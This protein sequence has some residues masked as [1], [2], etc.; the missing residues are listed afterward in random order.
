MATGSHPG[1]P[2]GRM[3]IVA[4][5]VQ[6][7]GTGKTTLAASLA[8]AAAE[9]GEQVCALD[10]DPQGSLAGWAALRGGPDPLVDRIQPWET[11]QLAE[12][13][14]QHAAQG[15]TLAILDTAGTAAAGLGLALKL[16]DLVLI[17]IRPSR[18]DLM[19]AQPT[20]HAMVR[21]GLRER[22]ALVLNQCP[23]APS[24]RTGL[25]AQQLRALGVLAEPALVQ[26]VDHQDA[27]A[28]G[29]GVTEQAPGAPAAE[30]VRALWAWVARRIGRG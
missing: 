30:E 26:R 16:A 21:Q 11:A 12:I 25:Y 20:I 7:G 17:P 19:A 29:F 10:L 9:A 3:R 5:A 2:P 15:R 28:L 18:L 24:P 14:E 8:V 23:P 1:R 6:K 27:L 13:L 4:L 22:V